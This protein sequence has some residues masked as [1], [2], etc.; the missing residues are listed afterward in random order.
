MLGCAADLAGSGFMCLSAMEIQTAPSFLPVMCGGGFVLV[1]VVPLAACLLWPLC[2]PVLILGYHVS[3]RPPL[4]SA[5]RC[6]G[7][8]LTSVCCGG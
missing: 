1:L 5:C 7:S 2:F 4:R 6:C 8:L 3:W